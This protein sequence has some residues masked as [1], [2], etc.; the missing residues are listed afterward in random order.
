MPI[1]AEGSTSAISSAGDVVTDILGFMG[2]VVTTVTSTPILMAFVIGVPL[3]SLAIGLFKRL[4]G[5]RA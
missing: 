5:S 3:L 2:D 1:L 4:I